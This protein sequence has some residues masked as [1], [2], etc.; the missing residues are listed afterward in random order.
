[1]RTP[2]LTCAAIW[3]G[4]SIRPSPKTRPTTNTPWKARTTCPLTS[5][6]QFSAARFRYRWDAA[7][8]SSA[9]GRESTFANIATT[10][11]RDGWWRLCT[12]R[13]AEGQG[14]KGRGRQGDRETRRGGDKI[15]LSPCLLVSPSPCLSS[16]FSTPTVKCELIRAEW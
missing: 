10:A 9:P 2:T 16:Y 7:G 4:T 12:E 15:S 14:D 8:Y 11:A 13:E 5:N 3:S 6:R 1:M